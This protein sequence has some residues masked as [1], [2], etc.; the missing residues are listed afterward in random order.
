MKKTTRGTLAAAAAALL[1]F[2]GIGTHATW[3]AD[4][5]I[6]GTDVGVGH[7]K[8]INADCGDG[9]L[10]GADPFDP[11]TIKVV[12]GTVLKLMCDFEV[13]A[14]GANLKANLAV[15]TPSLT[16]DTDLASALTTSATYEDALGDPIAATT[17]LSDGDVVQATIK[18][19]LPDTVDNAVQDL[20]ATL[21]DITVTV[22]QA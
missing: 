6:D 9:W 4:H 8:L 7:L 22:T 2:G 12:P 5:A 11:A 1:L 18:V 19:T 21:G 14:L 13:D 17:D 20:S 16:G 3:T 10:I 15:T